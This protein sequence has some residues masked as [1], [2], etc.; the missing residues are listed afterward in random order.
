[1]DA[2]QG[3]HSLK[4]PCTV[5]PAPTIIPL[6]YSFMFWKKEKILVVSFIQRADT[7]Q[8]SNVIIVIVLA[9]SA[10]ECR[11]EGYVQFSKWKAPIQYLE[12]GIRRKLTR[13][14]R[15]L[16]L[17]SCKLER[18][19]GDGH[20]HWSWTF[21]LKIIFVCHGFGVRVSQLMIFHCLFPLSVAR[22]STHDSALDSALLPTELNSQ[23]ATVHF[24]IYFL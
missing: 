19:G 24:F 23:S 22:N 4:H 3:Y 13:S 2:I 12:V 8:I 1:M 18:R 14:I 6:F 10:S 7:S 17:A 16:S 11:Q 20:Q 9:S 21:E 15:C 5:G